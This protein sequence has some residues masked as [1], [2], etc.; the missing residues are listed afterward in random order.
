MN[1]SA[2]IHADKLCI[3][4]TDDGGQQHQLVNQLSLQILPG[5][6][7]GLV[8][9][10]GCGKSLTAM[11]LMGL[12]P[13]PQ[14][15]ISGGR[16]HYCGSEIDCRDAQAFRSLRSRDIA[17][18]FQ[19]PMTALNPVHTIAQQIGETLRLHCPELNRKQR[20]ERCIALLQDVG[21]PAAEQRLSSYP[22]QL[23][24][25]MRQ[26]VM[27]AMALAGEPKLLI[28][29]EPTTA[30]DVT[31][32]AQILQLLKTQQQKRD[33][34][35]LFIT[36]D[37]AL[38]SQLA[39]RVAVMYAGEIVEQNRATAL[40]AKPKHPYTKGLLAALPAKAAA[41]K[42]RLNALG[43]QVPGID[44]MPPGC[45]FANR[46]DHATPQCQQS[47]PAITPRDNGAEIACHHWR[48]IDD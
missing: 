5:E 31:I 43:G 47:A 36:H 32:Q 27:I 24:G 23:S 7:L 20:R 35:M 25:G 4:I 45:R 10:S 40:F 19:D 39:D 44:A 46:C 38:V 9:E 26:R 14:A 33:M 16:I 2:V 22:H 11:S 41:P 37:L 30:L 3:S 13:R 34:A 8:G 28:A 12:L 17:V 1:E 18:I 21:M 29:D 42:S 48:V 6:T 15:E